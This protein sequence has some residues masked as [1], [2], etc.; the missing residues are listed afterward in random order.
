MQL[1]ASLCYDSITAF[2]DL[3]LFSCV[4]SNGWFYRLLCATLTSSL[5]YVG[6]RSV[7]VIAL[8][9][10]FIGMVLAVQAHGAVRAARHNQ[11][12]PDHQRFDYS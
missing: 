3:A 1:L 12:G 4:S 7:P 6:V 11:A 10:T 2:G 9:G 5:Y 8:T